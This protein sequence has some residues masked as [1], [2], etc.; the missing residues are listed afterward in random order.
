MVLLML[1][2]VMAGC[3]GEQG[4][5]DPGAD[6]L[7]MPEQY[8]AL[9]PAQQADYLEVEVERIDPAVADKVDTGMAMGETAITLVRPYLPEPWGTGVVALLGVLATVWSAL[10]ASRVTGVLSRVKRG[11]VITAGTVDALVRANPELWEMFKSRQKDKSEGTGAI[12][13]DKIVTLDD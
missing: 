5:Y 6:T 7:I 4:Y 12:M 11:A 10:K 9:P 1:V 13:P 3:A 2:A 8:E